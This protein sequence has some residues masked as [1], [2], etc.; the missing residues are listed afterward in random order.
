VHLKPK[1]IEAIAEKVEAVNA[2]CELAL[3]ALSEIELRAH[4]MKK[5]I[6]D[7]INLTVA[8]G[9][10]PEMQELEAGDLDAWVNTVSQH[11]QKL[12]TLI[13]EYGEF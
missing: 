6:R 8:G 7:N 5:R 11:L 4:D 9:D 3:E 12:R 1:I 13:K 2:E 10:V